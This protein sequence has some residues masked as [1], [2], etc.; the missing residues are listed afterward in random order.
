MELREKIRRRRLELG[1][2]QVDLADALGYTNRATVAK[3]E[4]GVND[5]TQSKIERYAEALE[6]T[7]AYLMDWTDD[8]YNYALDPDGRFDSI[9]KPLLE[10]LMDQ[11]HNDEEAVWHAYEDMQ[12]A[13][14]MEASKE[15]KAPTQEDEPKIENPDIRMI[16]RAGRKMTPEQAETVRRY[17]EFMFPEAFKDDDT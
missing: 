15:Y 16:A 13:S 2:S 17:A 10:A 1:M 8:P 4:S 12:T 5:L 3:V 6:T 7:P 14:L 11:Y 9:P